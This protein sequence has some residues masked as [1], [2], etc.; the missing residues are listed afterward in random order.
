MSSARNLILG[1]V[2][3]ALC[4]SVAAAQQSDN[5]VVTARQSQMAL[6][7][8]NL[9]ILGQM[10]QGRAEYDADMAKAAAD[11]LAALAGTDWRAYFPDGTAVGEVE[12]TEALP[13]IW[14]N[15]PD[16][17]AKKQAS[18]EAADA[19]AEVAGTSLEALQGAM[20]GVAD[21]CS[22]CHKI[23]RQSN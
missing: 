13:A 14:E 1:L 15:L 6:H 7:A 11:N 18:A 23:Y 16:F 3:G 10:A 22:A 5:P 21:A 12:D 19:M 2:G 17:D 4:A 8:F 20:P 9:S